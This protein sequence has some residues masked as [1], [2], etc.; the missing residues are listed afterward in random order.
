MSAIFMEMVSAAE[1][2][3]VCVVSEHVPC[4]PSNAEN[5]PVGQV[6]KVAEGVA[7]PAP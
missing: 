5:V 4:V 2:T 1:T 3:C 6:S 7:E